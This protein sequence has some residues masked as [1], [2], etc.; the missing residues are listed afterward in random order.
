MTVKE[1]RVMTDRERDL[2]L[3]Q[4]QHDV[5]SDD[6]VREDARLLPG[7]EID[8]DSLRPVPLIDE[9]GEI[10]EAEIEEEILRGEY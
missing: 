9:E 6:F 10:V 2:A 8:P 1:V 5:T 4:P 7:H 3:E